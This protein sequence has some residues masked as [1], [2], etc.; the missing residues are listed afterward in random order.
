MFCSEETGLANDAS[1]PL[2]LRD[3][4]TA[5]KSMQWN[6]IFCCF[7]P[8]ADSFPQMPDLHHWVK[9]AWSMHNRQKTPGDFLLPRRPS[10]FLSPDLALRCNAM[11][12]PI[13]F[14]SHHISSVSIPFGCQVDPKSKTPIHLAGRGLRKGMI[15]LPSRLSRF[16]H[17]NPS[18]V[19]EMH[20][21][22]VS[23]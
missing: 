22:L 14:P 11:P 8:H 21:N 18:P 12:F 19:Q 23:V 5:S 16:E 15:P 4:M 17:R 7:P 6:N 13:Y 10:D 20:G 9:T 1:N 3:L 2:G